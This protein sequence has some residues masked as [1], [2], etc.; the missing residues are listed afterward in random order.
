MSGTVLRTEQVSSR[1]RSTTGLVSI[2]MTVLLVVVF[3]KLGLWQLDRATEKV[4][5][6]DARTVAQTRAPLDSLEDGFTA[7][8]LYRQ[9]K[10]TGS[11]DLSKQFLLD[12]RLHNRQPGYEVLTPFY[13]QS[14]NGVAQTVIMVNR[15]WVAGN[16]DR[17]VKPILVNSAALMQ[18]ST[19]LAGLLVTPSKGITLGDA[20]DETDQ[21]WPKIL[22]YPD[23]ETIAKKL[24]RI[25]VINAVII[26]SPNQAGNYTYNWQPVAHG[27]EKHYG[28]AFQW[29]AM[30]LAVLTLFV[31]LNFIKKDE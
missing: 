2:V 12:N 13:P 11:F 27:P 26:S 21:Q 22:Q 4:V 8:D 30:L 24:D 20:I 6:L 9:V 1:F 15:G 23:Y 25:E 3:A 5:M 19:E 29:F 18:E 31:Y 7:E 28:Y 14:G 17:T 10:L 16:A